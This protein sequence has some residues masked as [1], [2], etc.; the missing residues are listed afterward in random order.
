M[1]GLLVIPVVFL[2]FVWWFSSLK[3][4]SLDASSQEY[5]RLGEDTQL[6]VEEAIQRKKKAAKNQESK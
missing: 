1:L 6:R 5:S 4:R 3:R 2:A